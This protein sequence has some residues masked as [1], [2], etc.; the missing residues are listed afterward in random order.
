MS[1]SILNSLSSPSGGLNVV[2]LMNQ[3]GG[4]GY[5]DK[6]AK[7]SGQYSDKAADFKDATGLNMTKVGGS[8]CCFCICF[9]IFIITV[10]IW[11]QTPEE[12]DDGKKTNKGDLY[13]VWIVFGILAC[14]SLTAF[15]YYLYSKASKD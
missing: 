7:Y 3:L 10:C 2:Q 6:M 13:I 12:D 8:C 11:G 15:I 14:I 5:A 9:I 4:D 1:D